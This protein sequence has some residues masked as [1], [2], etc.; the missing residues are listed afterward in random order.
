[1]GALSRAQEPLVLKFQTHKKK[2]NNSAQNFTPFHIV[3]CS[4][5]CSPVPLYVCCAIC[6]L[7]FYPK[8]AAATLQLPPSYYLIREP[9]SI[10][11]PLPGD[12]RFNAP[13]LSS[14]IWNRSYCVSG[15]VFIQGCTIPL[16]LVC[17]WVGVPWWRRLASCVGWG[18]PGR[19]WLAL[20]AAKGP[21]A[22]QY[23]RTP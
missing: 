13:G 6:R 9:L 2:G 1:M 17:C 3:P 23:P 5:I 20:S 18:P 10:C 19:G 7:V 12:G 11:L 4:C 15:V 22:L 21:Q 14:D 16:A 8:A